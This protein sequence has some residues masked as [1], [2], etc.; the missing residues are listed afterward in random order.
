VNLA[1]GSRTSLNDLLGRLETLLEAPVKRD[2]LPSREGDVR[3]SQADTTRLQSLFPD[4]TPVN[5]DDG[6]AAT[7]SWFRGLA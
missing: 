5:L 6:L 3:H 7:V 4:V 1:F 2:Y